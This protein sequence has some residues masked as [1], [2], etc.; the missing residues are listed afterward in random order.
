MILFTGTAPV[1]NAML[2]GQVDYEC[3]PVLGTLSQVQA[4]NVKALAIAAK[5]RS[6]LLPDVPTSH[7]QGLPEFDIAPFY[8]VFVPHGTPQAVVEKLADAMSKGLNEEA[9]Q[10]RL[11]ELGADSVEQYAP[12]IKSPCGS[13]QKRNRAADANSKSRGGEV[14]AGT[15]SLLECILLPVEIVLNFG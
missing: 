7:E 11:T 6:P 1:L 8:G 15:V 4:G 12:Q 5:K 14:S 2:S 9:V 13:G 10:K 3:Y